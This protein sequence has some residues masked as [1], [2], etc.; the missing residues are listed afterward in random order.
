MKQILNLILQNWFFSFFFFLVFL[1]NN[2]YFMDP[3][4]IINFVF[5]LL[6]FFLLSTINTMSTSVEKPSKVLFYFHQFVLVYFKFLKKKKIFLICLL[7][8]IYKNIV[9]FFFSY[10]NEL[11]KFFYS[12]IWLVFNNF[13]SLCIKKRNILF[14]YIS[15]LISYYTLVFVSILLIHESK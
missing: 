9:P 12:N 15:S 13:C 14:S 6:F 10:F 8:E 3:S 5:V 4:I 1:S 2:Y 11:R 7:H